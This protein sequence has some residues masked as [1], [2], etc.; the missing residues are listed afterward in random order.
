MPALR[1]RIVPVSGGQGTFG[2]PVATLVRNS[3]AISGAGGIGW[4][5]GVVAGAEVGQ[6]TTCMAAP[7]PLP[8]APDIAPAFRT[9]VAT[10]TPKVP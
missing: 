2:V 8:P 7:P 6:G 9:K 10:G 5:A 4:A 3:G 1:A